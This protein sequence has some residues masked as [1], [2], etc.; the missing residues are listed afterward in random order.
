M[1]RIASRRPETLEFS[2]SAESSVYQRGLADRVEGACA[3]EALEK[4][5]F[6]LCELASHL[7]TEQVDKIHL[8]YHWTIRQVFEHCADAERVFGYRMLRI[9]AGDPTPLPSWDENAYADSRFGLG[10][11]TNLVN[12]VAMLRQ[13][14]LLLLRRI[15]PKAWDRSVKVNG[16]RMTVRA[17][18]W[19]TAGHL[20][21]H[22]EIVEARCG[23][24]V[25]RA[26]APNM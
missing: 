23:M 16:N 24:T 26:P 2:E 15:E 10:T 19:V 17:I 13:S 22:F 3:L 18:A 4:Q 11:F 8:P 21:H 7:S 14:N 12:E 9:A 20:H 25:Q 6:W 1:N 5:L